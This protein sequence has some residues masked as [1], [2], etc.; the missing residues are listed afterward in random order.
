MIKRALFSKLS[1]F[2]RALSQ[3][4][5]VRLLLAIGA[6][7][8]CVCHLEAALKMRQAYISQHLMALRQAGILTTRRD[9]RYIFYRLSDPEMTAFIQEAARLA[10]IQ[11][12]EGAM[13]SGEQ[14]LPEC[15][16]PKCASVSEE[17]LSISDR[18]QA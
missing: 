3:P 13:T 4:A 16:C 5:R 15:C 1:R 8:A 17:R 18:V 9:G 2:F 7:E 10:G 11:G 14:W 12:G 6:G